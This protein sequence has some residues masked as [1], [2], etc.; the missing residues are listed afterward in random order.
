MITKQIENAA[1]IPDD[2]N[3]G[4]EESIKE[5]GPNIET[6]IPPP[7]RIKIHIAKRNPN[8]EIIIMISSSELLL[9]LPRNQ[10]R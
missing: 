9:E 10:K 5:K 2:A 4:S 8:K 3:Q 1:L 6:I 7:T